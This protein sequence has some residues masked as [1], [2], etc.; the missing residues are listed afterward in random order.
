MD[1]VFAD[2]NEDYKVKRRYYNEVIYKFKFL[3]A[4]RMQ[5]YFVVTVQFMKKKLGLFPFQCFSSLQMEGYYVIEQSG[6]KS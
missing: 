6:S 1:K 3:A 5:N 4:N 2:F